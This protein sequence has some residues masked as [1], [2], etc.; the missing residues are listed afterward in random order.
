MKPKVKRRARHVDLE[1]RWQRVKS[2][3]LDDADLL[4]TQGTFCRKTE[5]DHPI[6]RLRYVDRRADGKAVH[7]A[8]GLGSN[9]EFLRR[10]QE[11]LARC[12]Q[13]GIR[14]MEVENMRRSS[15]TLVGLLRQA[16]SKR[17]GSHQAMATRPQA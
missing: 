7:R 14:E 15:E 16:I 10:T 12:H 6:W 4:A 17:S 2:K 1:A 3:I 8:I 5:A 13:R 9:P 11:L